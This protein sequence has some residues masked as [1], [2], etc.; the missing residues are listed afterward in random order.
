M[1]RL[2]FFILLLTTFSLSAQKKGEEIPEGWRFGAGLGFDIGQLLQINPKQGAGQNKLGF[3]SAVNGFV[4]YKR[5]RRDWDNTVLWQ[6][7]LQRLGAGIIANGFDKPIPF[8]KTVDE[9]RLGSKYGY[10]IR[11]TGD[12]FYSVNF[13]FLS[14]LFPT[15]QFPDIYSGNFIADFP[16]TGRSPLARFLAPAT[17]TLSVGIDYQPN[18]QLSLF[19]SPISSKYVIVLN[20][21]IAS[22]GVQGNP[23][24]GEPN[25]LG[26]Y[27]EY[28][29]IDAQIGAL[30]QAEY[31]AS[32]L[33]DDRITLTSKLTLYSNYL[34]NPQNVDVDWQNSLAF[35]ITENLQLSVFANLFYD[36]D[37]LVRITDY[38]S[39]NGT[40]G[41]GKRVSF[42]E[43]VL[44]TYARTF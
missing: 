24:E 18:D 20:D 40:A 3:G 34:R 6:F 37:I 41:L 14:Q 25:A 8:Q 29:K 33:T 31:A 44:L 22:R 12:L 11:E 35:G 7:G 4:K 19:F 36:D 1:K 27:P 43:Q 30:V 10:R 23:V 9:L 26:I 16:D 28:Q 38:N 21:S 5:G 15:Y 39:P 42:T 13:T 32:F 17:A 2:L